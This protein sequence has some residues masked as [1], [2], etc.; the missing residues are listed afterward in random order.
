MLDHLNIVGG[1]NAFGSDVTV[2]NCDVEGTHFYAVYANPYAHITVE[3]GNFALASTGNSALGTAYTEN[4]SKPEGNIDVTGGNFEIATGKPVVLAASAADHVQIS[5]GTFKTSSDTVATVPAKYLVTH[6]VQDTT[7]GVVYLTEPNDGANITVADTISQ[8]FYFD[9]EFYGE[10]AYVSVEYNHNSNATETPDVREETKKLSALPALNDASSEFD[11]NRMFSVLQAPAQA[12]EPIIIKVYANQADAQADE[13]PIREINYNTYTYCREILEGEYPETLKELAET[14]LD[15][16]AAA[17]NYFGYN[18]ENMATTDN[19]GN[20]FYNNVDG[21]DFEGVAGIS[22]PACIKKASLVVKSDLEINL[23]SKEEISVNGG[24]I[25]VENSRFFVSNEVEVNGDYYVIHI[26]GIEAANMNKTI[27]INTNLGTIELTANAIM[28]AFST[29][30]DT[31][32]ATLAKAM[33]LYG[34]AANS[35][36]A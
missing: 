14:T 7:T 36:F 29:N 4:P 1:I 28:K 18:T 32:L 33:Y 24:S 12:T 19:A 35:F 15:Y 13:N 27:T 17:Q 10:D 6:Y 9:D 21:A 3:S 8:N 23:L 30:S 31:N 26:G 20:N 16:A 2:K 11:G 5:G 34:Q 22:K 25:D